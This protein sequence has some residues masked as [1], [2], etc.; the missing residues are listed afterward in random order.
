[1]V[2]DGFTEL[3]VTGHSKGGN[4]AMF[5]TILCN[6]VIRCVSFDGEGFSKEFLSDNNKIASILERSSLITN[7][8]LSSDF[9]HILLY[10]LR[11][12]YTVQVMA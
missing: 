5:V 2:N 1:M 8:S 11:N 3:T 12:K 7:Y 6:N 4:K 10:Q 9:V